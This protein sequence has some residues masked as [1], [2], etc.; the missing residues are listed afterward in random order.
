MLKIATRDRSCGRH[1]GRRDAAHERARRCCRRIAEQDTDAAFEKLVEGHGRHAGEHATGG[2]RR[3]ALPMSLSS[4]A[5][6]TVQRFS[7]YFE[8][9]GFVAVPSGAASTSTVTAK[10]N[11]R[12]PSRPAIRS[13]RCSSTATS[14]SRPAA[15]SPIVDGDH[16]YAFG[17]PFLDMGEINFP[18]ATS[19]G[20]HRA[21]E[22]GQLVQV[23]EYRSH[24]RRAAA[25]S[26][27]RHH[28]HPR[29]EGGHD[30]GRGRSLNGSGPAQTYHVNVVRHSH[31]SP[32]MLAM[33]TDSV[34]ANAQRA[35]GERTVMMEVGDQAQGLRADPS[36]RRM[37]RA[38]GAPVDSAVPGRRRRL[39]DVERVPR[40]GDREREDPP[41]PRRR[42]AHRQADGS[43]AGA[44]RTRDTS[45]PATR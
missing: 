6:E 17:H 37:G 42:S 13:A 41:P 23:L 5:P 35:A 44:R 39:P 2:V 30:P 7:P 26:R 22:P 34:V 14:T 32:L 16:V 31:L 10:P 4:F 27:R 12:R 38:A 20:R 29:R 33:V 36:A 28:G 21:A 15:P 9:L 11:A 25:G 43:V 24:R 19:R 3:I 18:M 8:Q 40:R 1:A 45:R